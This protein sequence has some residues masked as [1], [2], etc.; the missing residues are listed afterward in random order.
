MKNAIENIF[1]ECDEIK[2]YF[3]PQSRTILTFSS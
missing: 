1:A 2:P 3:P